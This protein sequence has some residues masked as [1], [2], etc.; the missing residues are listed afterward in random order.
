MIQCFC[1]REISAGSVYLWILKVDSHV[2]HDPYCFLGCHGGPS[3]HS[4]GVD[5]KNCWVSWYQSCPCYLSKCCWFDHHRGFIQLLHRY[6][7]CSCFSGRQAL[8]YFIAHQRWWFSQCLSLQAWFHT[9][10]DGSSALRCSKPEDSYWRQY[11][12]KASLVGIAI[13]RHKAPFH[14]YTC[15]FYSSFFESLS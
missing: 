5:S 10:S 3:T 15:W 12:S 11:G 7:V 9:W 8:W 2:R 14:G 13:I 4:Q 6:E 1:A